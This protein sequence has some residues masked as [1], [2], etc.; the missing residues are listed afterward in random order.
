MTLAV[1]NAT[2]VVANDAGDVIERCNVLV[3]D[4]GAI[5]AVTTKSVTASEVIDA[6]GGIVMPGIVNAHTHLA[7]TLFRGL[8]DDMNLEAFLDRLMPAEFAVLSPEA[9]AAGTRLAALES[10]RGGITS[11]LDMYYFPESIVNVGN[12]TGMRILTGPTLLEFDG[13]EKLAFDA[14]LEWSRR[15]LA[16]AERFGKWLGPHSTYLLSKEQLRHIAALASDSGASIHV[17]AAETRGEM[18]QVATRHQ[19]RTPVQVLHDTGLL[20]GAVLAHGV[21]LSDADIALVAEHGASV[22]HCPA[23]NL[24][25]ASGFARVIDLMRAGANVALGT[26]GPASAN[27]L[28][29][30]L[31]MR[32]AGYVQKN[33]S[34]DPAQLTAAQV[35]RMATLNGARALGIDDLVGS[36]EVGKQADLVVLDPRSPSLMPTF[37]AHVALAASAGRG[38]VRDVIADGHVVVRDRRVQTIDEAAVLAEAAEYASQIKA[39]VIV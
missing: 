3:N 9:V 28:D 24:K 22:T 5:E 11:A 13:P 14:R 15:W 6:E 1:T 12:E 32:L 29:M 30:W 39:A 25:L 26:D 38:D 33:L 23:S 8:A 31:A 37:D 4:R 18:N 21:H 10:L 16:S 27:D 2:V 20:P 34:G 7:M 35:V 36:I 19:G 17:H